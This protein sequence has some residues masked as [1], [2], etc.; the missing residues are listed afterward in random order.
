MSWVHSLLTHAARTQYRESLGSPQSSD[1]TAHSTFFY[2]TSGSGK[3]YTVSYILRSSIKDALDA[4]HTVNIS[5]Y[6]LKHEVTKVYDLLDKRTGPQ[7]KHVQPLGRTGENL[8]NARQ[9]NIKGLCQRRI[10]SLSEWSQAVRDVELKQTK[11]ATVNNDASSRTHS[12]WSLV[13]A[14]PSAPPFAPLD[15]AS[16]PSSSNASQS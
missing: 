9:L 15:L 4:S 3:T 5:V 2:G 6:E 12:V 10:T 16:D 13:R 1:K 7:T 11:G 8:E 14:V